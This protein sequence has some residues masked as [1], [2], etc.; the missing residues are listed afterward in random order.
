MAAIRT[1]GFL[2]RSSE[3]EVLDRL[4]DSVRGGQSD[5]LV[6][7]GEAGIG[8]TALLRYTAR[9][10]SGFRVAQVA[11]IEAEMELPFAGL[12]QLCAPMLDRLDRLP[13]PQ[14]DALCIALGLASGGIPDR[15]LVALAVLSLLSVVA[16]ERPLLCLVDDAQW[17]DRATDHVLGFVARRLLAESVAMVFAIRSPGRPGFDGLRELALGGLTL[18]DGRALLGHVVPGRLDDRVRDRLIAETGG[19]P[20]ALLE[21][22]RRMSAA[23]LA[24]GFEL[25][26]AVELSS[27]LEDRYLESI[28]ALPEATQQLLLL[29]AADPVGDATLVWRAAQRLGIEIGALAAA[30]DAELLEIGERVRFRHPLVRSAVYRA[31]TPGDRQRAHEA[32]AEASDPEL[33][34]D[35][36]V[37]HRALAAT[38]PD[39][40]LAAEL[41]HSAGRAHTRGG[42][43]GAAAFLAKA[44]ALTVDPGVRARRELGA[45]Q[46]QLQAGAPEEALALLARAQAGPLDELQRAQ[47]DVLRARITF[48]T[49]RG[50]DAPALL[51]D[52][53]RQLEPL[54]AVLARET[55]LEAL[56]AAQFAGRYAG[57]A[58]TEVAESARAAP[59]P[60][61]PRAPDLLLDGLAVLITEGHASAAPLL[62]RALS[63]FRDGDVAAN[64]G[65]RW[66]W[67]A[68]E[69]AIEVWDHDTW[70]ALARREIKLVREAGALTVLPLALSAN[71]VGRIF[72][73]ELDAAAA[74]IDEVRV[75]VE[76]TG[77][78]LAPYGPLVLAAWRGRTDELAALAE[79]TLAEVQDRGEGI[80]LSTAQWARALLD[81][82]RGRYDSALA[83]AQ[84]VL[85]P[86]KR[87][88]ATVGWVL[89][90][91]IEA[92]VR[93]GRVDLAADALDR[94][95]EMT[96][97]GGTDWALGLEARSRA[98]LSE[99]GDAEPLYREAIE[100]LRR[101]R[102]RGDHARAHLLYGEWLRREGRR[103]DARQQLGTAHAMFTDMGAEAFAERSRRE[104]LATGGTVRRRRAETRDELT[105][106]EWQIARLA[107][108]GLSNPE[109]GTRLF[110]SPRTVEWHLRKVFGKLGIRSRRELTAVLPAADAELT[111]A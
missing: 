44:S 80:G 102:V 38:G 91:V 90:E 62:K 98:L 69:A 42:V 34:A 67:L 49:N 24:G 10:A 22:P 101:T 29:A 31:V 64:G 2:G 59:S 87:L 55:Y 39:E 15:F 95:A 93:T 100:R 48:T 13:P 3:R 108:D 75:V 7:R 56:M 9:Q 89:P 28:G 74:L 70:V 4:L 71:I 73:G 47:A 27:H 21:L 35:R 11:G 92:A 82:G 94:L 25:P 26:A 99:D 52:A 41:E 30:E 78:H 57:A 83:A 66:M 19:N 58:A 77:T 1:P 96:R 54:D 53:A 81:N 105:A 43:A 33:D 23:E 16:E 65:F 86:P 40:E 68:E 85:E 46:A 5:V 79:T 51:L 72:A 103:V 107:R 60:A 88:D 14:H 61:A 12:H 8:K 37:W 110:L 104:L 50:S 18:D 32:L 97:A 17:L 63:A 76:A 45:A 84:Q 6:V 109:I 106:Q 36:R 20:L 111:T